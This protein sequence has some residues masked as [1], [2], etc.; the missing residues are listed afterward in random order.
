MR[1][2]RHAVDRLMEQLRTCEACGGKRRRCE[3]ATIYSSRHMIW[4]VVNDPDCQ[5]RT[6]RSLINDFNRAQY[7]L[8]AVGQLSLPVE[9]R[10]MYL[11]IATRGRR[12]VNILMF[13][14]KSCFCWSTLW[15][16]WER[17]EKGRGKIHYIVKCICNKQASLAK[18]V[19]Y[20]NTQQ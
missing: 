19:W 16:K 8:R 2:R 4:R 15:K 17:I 18:T 14:V 20:K 3:T 10:L 1:T 11:R 12:A 5:A 9:R 6:D 7:L 13:I